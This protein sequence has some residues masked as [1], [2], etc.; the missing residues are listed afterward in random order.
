MPSYLIPLLGLLPPID[1][2]TSPQLTI[3][4]HYDSQTTPHNA[5]HCPLYDPSLTVH[6]LIFCTTTPGQ[7]HYSITHASHYGLYYFLSVNSGAI[8]AFGTVHCE[9]TSLLRLLYDYGAL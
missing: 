5:Y 9:Y 7:K 1:A 8:L 4:R 6:S 2:P 3:L